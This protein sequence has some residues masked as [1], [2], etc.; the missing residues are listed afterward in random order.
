MSVIFNPRNELKGKR[1]SLNGCIV[2]NEFFDFYASKLSK[3]AKLMYPFICRKTLGWGKDADN[4]STSQLMDYAGIIDKR[5][6]YKAIKELIDNGLIAKEVNHKKGNKY[7]ILD[8]SVGTLNDTTAL[9]VVG[10]LNDTTV[11]TL[12]DT[13]VGTL[14]ATNNKQENNKTI[15]KKNITKKDSVLGSNEKQK[16]T[17]IKSKAYDWKLELD[18]TLHDAFYSYL[19][20]RTENKHKLTSRAIQLLVKKIN[21]FDPSLRLEIIENATVSNWKSFYHNENNLYGLKK[22]KLNIDSNKYNNDEDDEFSDLM[23]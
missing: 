7:I 20:M 19:E 9:N 21:S 15:Y 8:I 6:I 13:T 5:T 16:V 18:S 1:F 17:K 14:N 10:T 23:A 22:T 4:I 3:N 11:G 2:P 12:N